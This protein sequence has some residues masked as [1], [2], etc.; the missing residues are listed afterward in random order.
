MNEDTSWLKGGGEVI[1]LLRVL[2]LAS[3]KLSNGY[4]TEKQTSNENAGNC[5]AVAFLRIPA[6]APG[7]G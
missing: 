5:E 3:S 4:Y 2:T 7:S 1:H 6:G